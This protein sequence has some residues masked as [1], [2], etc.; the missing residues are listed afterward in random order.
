M[1]IKFIN[2]IVIVIV[3]LTFTSCKT[4]NFRAKLNQSGWISKNN[5]YEKTVHF[6]T[7]RHDKYK[8]LKL[9][10]ICNGQQVLNKSVID[11]NKNK[12]RYRTSN[13][14][15]SRETVEYGVAKVKIPLVKEQGVTSGMNISYLR[16]NLKWE[17]FIANLSDDDLLVFIHGFN[18]PFVDAIIRAAQIGHDTNFKGEVV[19]F[20]W[21]SDNNIEYAREKMRAEENYK[22]LAT[23]LQDLVQANQSK[24]INILAHSMGTYILMDALVILD[25]QIK[26]Y[27][28]PFTTTRGALDKKIFNQIILAAPDIAQSDFRSKFKN[29]EFSNLANRFTLYSSNKDYVLKGSRAFNYFGVEGS[30]EIRLG[31]SSEK[32]FVI[33]DMDT[34]DARQ[35][36]SSQIFGHSFYAEY[37]S[38]VTDMHLLLNHDAGPDERML[39]KVSDSEDNELWF[40]R[41]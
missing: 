39:Q 40:I 19:L 33:D 20:S 38:M 6:A 5:F 26:S 11:C 12:Y 24:K 4:L 18:T 1:K 29:H 21:P 14:K 34:I 35:E 22:P 32:F 36:I 16:N 28:K 2:S 23:F 7:T 15:K 13:L 17:K 31:S 30:G 3:V 27:D 41:D 25:K 10:T 37:R 8:G 9:E